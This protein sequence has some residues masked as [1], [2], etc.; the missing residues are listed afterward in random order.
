MIQLRSHRVV[1]THKTYSSSVFLSLPSLHSDSSLPIPCLWS[2]CLVQ[3]V[4]H[5]LS[6]RSIIYIHPSHSTP[7]STHNPLQAYTT[8]TRICTR[9]LLVSHA[10][11]LSK[12][13]S[14][15]LVTQSAHT[16]TRP[17]AGRHLC[18]KGISYHNS[19]LFKPATFADTI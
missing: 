13:L 8:A 4:P 7:L 17:F 18:P 1:L 12:S 16:T 2:N 3:H 19:D 11:L 9:S 5:K 10:K 6:S 15:S 14:L